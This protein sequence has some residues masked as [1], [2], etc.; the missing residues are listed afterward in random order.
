[1]PT[2]GLAATAST[3]AS[4]AEV[5]AVGFPG[6]SRDSLQTGVTEP[7][8]VFGHISTIRHEATGDLIEIDA[9]TQPGMSGGPVID[10]QGDVIGLTSFTLLQ[11]SGEA[12]AKY[13]RTVD[14]IKSALAQAGVTPQRGG[15]DTSFAAAMD[16]FWSQHY[17][18]SIPQFQR[19]I[20][21]WDG[22]PLAKEYL[23]RGEQLRGTAQ[24]IPV[25]PRKTS[26]SFP[27]VPVAAGVVVLLLVVGAL[28]MRSRRRVP[29]QSAAGPASM[30]APGEPAPASTMSVAAPT[31]PLASVSGPQTAPTPMPSPT[32]RPV[33]VGAPAEGTSSPNGRSEPEADAAPVSAEH[34]FCASCGERVE[35][36]EHLCLKCGHPLR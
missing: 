14:D 33:S 11:A 31:P 2:V 25:T 22:H 17:S 35:P 21:L 19:T 26:S 4:G 32:P 28:L 7:T 6:S 20:A 16:L 13:L 1:M 9:A 23:A 27:L 30:P 36:D 5:T 18:A 29:A 10:A 8:K 24:D 3:L 12:G 15:V 34:H